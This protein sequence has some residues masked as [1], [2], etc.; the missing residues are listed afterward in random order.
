[1]QRIAWVWNGN[2]FCFV[3]G[4]ML[5][6][7]CIVCMAWSNTPR[8]CPMQMQ[9]QML[10]PLSLSSLLWLPLPLLLHAASH[11]LSLSAF[12]PKLLPKP[13]FQFPSVPW[14][15]HRIVSNAGISI[16]VYV[17]MSSS[18]L[19]MALSLFTTHWTDPIWSIFCPPKWVFLSVNFWTFSDSNF[20]RFWFG[21]LMIWVFIHWMNGIDC[22]EYC[23]FWVYLLDMC[24]FPI[25]LVL[26]SFLFFIVYSFWTWKSRNLY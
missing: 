15:L 21:L 3:V 18:A 24:F 12:F 26:G 16:T 13:S 19:F 20:T 4:G 8:I 5:F 6:G 22:N 17:C 25:L 14:I 1:M 9:M 23:F 2:C 7:V 10:S 11:S